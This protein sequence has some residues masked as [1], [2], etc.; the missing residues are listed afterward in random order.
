MLGKSELNLFDGDEVMDKPKPLVDESSP[1]ADE[2]E[3]Y[4]RKSLS[5]SSSS[6]EGNAV[7]AAAEALGVVGVDLEDEPEELVDG[8]RR[9][10]GE[11]EEQFRGEAEEEEE[12]KEEE[13]ARGDGIAT[14]SYKLLA[15]VSFGDLRN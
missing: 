9:C 12:E 15:R 10:R 14:L 2:D 7:S 6:K 8:V 1:P 13:D 3:V 5:N 11:E 4:L